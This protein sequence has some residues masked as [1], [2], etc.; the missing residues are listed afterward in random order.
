MLATNAMI[1]ITPRSTSRPSD[2]GLSNGRSHV[3]QSMHQP[4]PVVDGD[5][6]MFYGD[7][8]MSDGDMV[9]SDG[10]MVMFYGDMERQRVMV[11]W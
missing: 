3:Q 1:F 6:V 9:M 2:P 10:D 4:H 8:V 7:I 5:M 11:T